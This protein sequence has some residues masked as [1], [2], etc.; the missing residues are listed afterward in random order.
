M[1]KAEDA[2][3]QGDSHEKKAAKRA[4]RGAAAG[5][6][7]GAAVGAITDNDIGTGAVAGAA[8]GGVGSFFW[9]LF[10]EPEP[11]PVFKRFVELCLRERGYQT[12]GWK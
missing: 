8:G 10:S 7:T 12:V 6:A 9:N 3:A 4:G 5:A 11:D 2:G 1:Q